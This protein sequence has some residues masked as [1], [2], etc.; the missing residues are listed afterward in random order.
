MKKIQ[1]I[2]RSEK[3]SEVRKGLLEAN[4]LGI[5]V[6]D[7]RGTGKKKGL[8][9]QFRKK[10]YNVDLEPKTR[11]DLMV[12][13]KDTEKVVNILLKTAHTGNVGDGKIMILP[14][15]DIIRIRTGE[16]GKNAF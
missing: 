14:M 13:D 8:E 7:V 6:C 11:I 4:I 1:A 9:I 2:I 5:T 16:R 15:D 3:L 12:N 10:M